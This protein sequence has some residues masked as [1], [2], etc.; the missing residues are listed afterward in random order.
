MTDMDYTPFMQ[1]AISLAERGSWQTCPNPAVGAVLVRDGVIVARGWHQA[2]GQDH[3]EVACLKDAAERG[4]NPA[5]CT[6]LVTLEPCCHSGR[7][8]P[9][10]AAILQAGIRRV[11]IGAADPNPEACGGAQ[12]LRAAGI[13]VIEKVCEQE[14]R[15]LAADFFVWQQKRRPFVML[16]MAA[17]LD[18]RIATRAGHARWV[19]SALSR[20]AVQD[21]RRNI[22][23]CGKGAVLV[24]GGTFRTD[25]P[26]LGVH[27][28]TECQQ[29]LACVL[30]SRLPAPDA[31]FRLL[32]ERPTQTVFLASPAAAASTTAKAL[33]DKGVRVLALGPSIHGGPDFQG[34]LQKLRDELD[35]YYM[36]CEGGGRLAL[37]MLEAGLVDEFYLHLAP[38]VLGDAEAIPLFSGRSPLNIDE[39]LRL[40]IYRHSLCGEDIHIRLRP[41]EG[42]AA[43]RE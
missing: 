40:R 23:L 18:G 17:T 21:L 4:V 8:P 19:S 30:T 35:C 28:D 29:P 41:L 13:E 9:C 31:D 20:Q 12:E 1:E 39:A 14:C 16:K 5:E 2:A 25:N 34:L 32:K 33:R 7:V 37:S 22:A 38:L 15:D 10:T 43:H 27:D 42:A 11:V 3:A 6:M 26:H 24:G 36:L